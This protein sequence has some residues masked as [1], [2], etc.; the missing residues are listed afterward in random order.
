MSHIF[1]NQAL[2]WCENPIIHEN[3]G[4]GKGDFGDPDGIHHDE[5]RRSF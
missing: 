4:H 3:L 2:E 5:Q 1:F